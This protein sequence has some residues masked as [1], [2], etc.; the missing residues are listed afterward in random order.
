MGY[1]Q[2][3]RESCETLYSVFFPNGLGDGG[4]KNFMLVNDNKLV[5]ISKILDDRNRISK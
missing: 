5:V 2:G 3:H 1:D 4:N